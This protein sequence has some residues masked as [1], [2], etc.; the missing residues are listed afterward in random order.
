MIDR[1]ILSLDPAQLRDY[2]ALSAVRMRYDKVCRKVLYDLV[3]MERRQRIGYDE[4]VQWASAAYNT[5]DFHYR[6]LE[7]PLCL[8]DAT[9]PGLALRDM[10]RLNGIRVVPIM[11]TSG[12]AMT[13]D[14]PFLHIGK[15]RMFGTFMAALDSGRVQINPAM[16]IYPTLEREMVNFRAKLS[17]SGN[18]I[19]E[20][21]PGENDDLLFSLAMAVWYGEEVLRGSK[22]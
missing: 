2:S 6:S 4:I 22:I 15:P 18:A 16:P 19:F 9:G 5:P 1:Y 3:N 21:G 17:A 8:L 7:P 12:Q 10:F 20:A 14:G 13:R 11:I